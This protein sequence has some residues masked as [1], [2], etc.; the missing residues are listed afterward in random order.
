MTI[1]SQTRGIKL[2][3]KGKLG[4]YKII[5]TDDQTKTVY[6]EY[7]D[8][9]CHSLSGAL[10]ETLY[11]YINGCHIK[12]FL[13]S[14]LECVVLDVGFGLGMGLKALSLELDKYPSYKD[15]I[16]YFSIELDE[17]FFLWAMKE[18]FSHL[19]IQKISVNSL[20]YYQFKTDGI[21]PI[22][23]I[24]FIGD[25]RKT[26]VDAHHLKLIP[27]I[28]AIFQDAFSPKKNP[29]LWTVQWF[30]FLREISSITV[31]LSTYSSSI[32]IRKSMIAAGWSISNHKGFAQKKTMTKANLRDET[33]TEI[34]AELSRSPALELSDNSV[35][36]KGEV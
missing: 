22:E 10:D 20:T 36:I 23:A 6:S 26:L 14:N 27:P 4:Q 25:G 19:N 15:K 2:D 5:Q 21:H 30:T 29:A 24:V 18:L 28:N 12:Q 34:M 33:S 35:K 16:T 8:E 7:F 1:H 31:N 13:E 9:A 17:D 11:N 32:S 3:F